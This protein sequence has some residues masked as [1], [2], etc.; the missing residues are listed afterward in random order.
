MGGSSPRP[1]QS[2][3]SCFIAKTRGATCPGQGCRKKKQSEHGVVFCGEPTLENRYFT[4]FLRQWCAGRF[5]PAANNARVWPKIPAA[6]VFAR[7][8]ILQTDARESCNL[9]CVCP[10]AVKHA[11]VRFPLLR[12]REWRLHREKNQPRF[13]IF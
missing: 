8:L 2:A 12:S 11:R 13:E 6:P 9:A 4:A 7:L 10:V 1:P 5:L 3:T